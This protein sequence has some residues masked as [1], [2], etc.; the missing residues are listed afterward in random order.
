M[1]IFEG[2]HTERDSV[3]GLAEV[4]ESIRINRKFP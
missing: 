4:D 1:T 3:M 2:R